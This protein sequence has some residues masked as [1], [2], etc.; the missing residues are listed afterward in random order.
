[1]TR[2][3]STETARSSINTMRQ[4]I[5]SGL[6]EEIGRLA[7]EGRTLSQ[8]DV[9]DGALAAQFRA[10]WEATEASLNATRDQLERLR[11]QVE[12]VNAN[13]MMAGGNQ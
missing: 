8:P 6:S 3:L 12:R 9:W 11:T 2:V 13:I 5:G 1:M 7:R 4:I 10:D